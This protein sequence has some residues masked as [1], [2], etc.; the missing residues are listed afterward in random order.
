[1][2]ILL[3]VDRVLVVGLGL[4]VLRGRQPAAALAPRVGDGLARYNIVYYLLYY[5]ITY[6]V[7]TVY[8][9]IYIHTH[10]LA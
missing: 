2:Y 5:S 10:M 8:I 6:Y 4:P 1:M 3:Y 9:Y 7:I